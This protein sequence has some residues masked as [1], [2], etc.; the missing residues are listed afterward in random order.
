MMQTNHFSHALLTSLLLPKLLASDDARVVN[1]S[2][3]VYERVDAMPLDDLNFEQRW[4]GIWPYCVTKLANILFTNELH[5][6]THDS[7]LATFS[8]HPGIVASGFQKNFATPLRA[9]SESG[10]HSCAVPSRARHRSSNSPL[11]RPGSPMP[12]PTSIGTL[13]LSRNR[14]QL[15]AKPLNASG[16][17]LTRSQERNGQLM[18]NSSREELIAELEQDSKEF[19]DAV[20]QLPEEAFERGVYE[21][22]GTLDNCLPTSPR[23]SG[24]TPVSSSAPSNEP[25]AT[26]FPRRR[27]RL[28]HGRLQRQ[29]GRAS[30]RSTRGATAHRVPAQSSRHHRRHPSR[31]RRTTQQP[32]RSAGGVEGTLLDVLEGVAVGHV[33]EHVS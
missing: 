24:L 7:G 10:D 21:Q 11:T 8:V 28:R 32:T 22:V 19:Q 14:K 33:R 17:S 2:S 3:R 13:A 26:T 20:A 16:I 5:R 15:T 4:G 1:V 29:T 27:R 9:V 12:A 6:R 23:S 30:G 18:T 31:R 25:R